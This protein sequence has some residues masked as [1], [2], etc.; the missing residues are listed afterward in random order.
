MAKETTTSWWQYSKEKDY[1]VYEYES[2]GWKLESE[3]S[4]INNAGDEVARWTFSRD[5]DMENY[6]ELKDKWDLY[7]S[8]EEEMK[9]IAKKQDGMGPVPVKKK[10]NV[11]FALF[12]LCLGGF[13]LVCY[14][15]AFNAKN[16]QIEQEYLAYKEKYN[17]LQEDFVRLDKECE[18][19]MLEAK[20]LL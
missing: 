14:I 16:K 6:A 15:V 19:I 3:E 17:A 7:F 4:K 13:G 10:F 2:F 18:Q 9:A 11:L 8:K 20:A 12:S 1:T 5:T